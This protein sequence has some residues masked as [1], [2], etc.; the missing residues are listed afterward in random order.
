MTYM[1]VWMLL[2]VGLFGI[3]KGNGR[4]SEGKKHGA[5]GRLV[6]DRRISADQVG[7]FL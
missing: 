1:C 2:L 4:A 6:I 7:N 3:V 5:Q